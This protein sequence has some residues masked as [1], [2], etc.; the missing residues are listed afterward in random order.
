MEWG[1]GRVT[2]GLGWA[3]E[4]ETWRGEGALP[5]EGTGCEKTQAWECVWQTRGQQGGRCSWT[6]GKGPAPGAGARRVVWAAVWRASPHWRETEHGQGVAPFLRP[7]L[8]TG[9][10]RSEGAAP[11][12]PGEPGLGFHARPW[13]PLVRRQVLGSFRKRA[14]KIGEKKDLMW[15]VRNGDPSKQP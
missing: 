10:R 5:A 7:S 9:R 12:G 13:E 3:S 6:L 15:R 2:H 11:G 4:A 8:E 14:H 1:G